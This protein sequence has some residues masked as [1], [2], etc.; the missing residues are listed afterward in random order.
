M[1]TTER[2]AASS[3][4]CAAQSLLVAVTGRQCSV[5]SQLQLAS[6]YVT[7]F[8]RTHCTKS[9]WA[10]P[11]SL[12]NTRGCSVTIRPSF[13]GANWDWEGREEEG[14]REEREREGM[15]EGKGE[16]G[17]GRD[18]MGQGENGRRGTIAPKLQFLA[19]PMVTITPNNYRHF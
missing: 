18:G 4:V 6:W 9:F 2:G 13:T 11:L 5:P 1:C 12:H 8:Q 10:L 19:P 16:R 7:G 17:N 15:E 3:V 14:R